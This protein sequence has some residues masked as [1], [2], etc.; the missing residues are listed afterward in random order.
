MP[1]CIHL[2]S[3]IVSQDKDDLFF[4]GDGH[5]YRLP[6]TIEF[7]YMEDALNS[8]P[9]LLRSNLAE[10]LSVCLIVPA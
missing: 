8:F 6:K 1:Q 7:E 9:L 2:L 5:R 10:W 3:A 4:V